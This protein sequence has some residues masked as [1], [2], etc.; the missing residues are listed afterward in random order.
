MGLALKARK[1]LE[2]VLEPG[3][4]GGMGYF[5]GLTNASFRKDAQGRLL[6]GFCLIMFLWTLIAKAP[7][8]R[9]GT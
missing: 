6:F 5:D 2:S 4:L 1:R 8:E 3:R 7:Q 9:A